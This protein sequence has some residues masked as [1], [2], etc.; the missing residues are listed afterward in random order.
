MFMCSRVIFKRLKVR[1]ELGIKT[2]ISL[3]L[4][5][6]PFLG[7]MAPGRSMKSQVST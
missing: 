3:Y 6:N 4:I 1:A 5:D 7:N 2:A